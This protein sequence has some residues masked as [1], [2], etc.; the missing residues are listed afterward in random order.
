MNLAPR[1]K[2]QKHFGTSLKCV[3]V[4]ISMMPGTYATTGS[5]KLV[6]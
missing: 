2:A 6:S 1:S 5:S 3:T 4:H